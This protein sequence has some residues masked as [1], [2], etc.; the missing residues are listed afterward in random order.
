[1]VANSFVGTVSLRETLIWITIV[2]VPGPQSQS[3]GCYN[4]GSSFRYAAEGHVVG[5]HT[6]HMGRLIAVLALAVGPV[7][8]GAAALALGSGDHDD[9][10]PD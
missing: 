10:D 7:L 3:R 5:V 2:V 8:S 9:G 6:M 4:I 1:M